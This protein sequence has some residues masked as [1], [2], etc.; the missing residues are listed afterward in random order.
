MMETLTGKVAVVT[1]GAS[2]MGRAFV[3]RFAR[4]GMRVVIADVETAALDKAVAELEA[5][6][7]TVIGI[8]T[9]VSDEQQLRDLAT[10]AIEQFGAVNVVC[11]NAGVGGGNGPMDTLSIA[12]WQWVLGVNLWGIIHGISAFLPH[13]KSHGD[14]H[15]VITASIA[16]LTSFPNMG[17]Y[18]T[19]KHA[20]IAIAE[21]LFSEL[22]DQG[23]TVGVTCLCPGLVHTRINESERNRPEALRRPLIPDEPTAER[24]AMH[25]AVLEIFGQAKPPAQVADL[26]HD[27]VLARQFWVFTDEVFTPAIEQRLD[28]IRDRTDPSGSGSLLDVY[29]R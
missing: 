16:G 18:N 20:A 1:G 11:L 2:G 5:T 14:G 8:R 27:A 29:L 4:A 6:G 22:R 9:D 12:D 13:L 23:S 3:D 15:V 10:Q 24:A 21:T 19:T 28:S 7:A 26:I 17:P 25:K